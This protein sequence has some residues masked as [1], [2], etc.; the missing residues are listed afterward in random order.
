MALDTEIVGLKSIV[1]YV[2]EGIVIHRPD[3]TKKDRVEFTGNS[4][5]SVT[6]SEINQYPKWQRELDY[7]GNYRIQFDDSFSFFLHGINNEIP[8]IL[9][10]IRNNRLGYI[11]VI[12]TIDN[13]CYVFPTPVFI[14]KKNTKKENSNSSEVVLSYRVPT[15]ENKL[16]ISGI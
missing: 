14:D 16:I 10:E 9:Q 1:L 12:T 4:L 13:Y 2:N 7:S 8:E 11:A 5:G 3:I 15:F 6:V